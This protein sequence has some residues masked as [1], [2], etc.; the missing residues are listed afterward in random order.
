MQNAHRFSAPFRPLV[1]ALVLMCVMPRLHADPFT[2]TDKQGRSIKADVLSVSGDQVKIKR[3]DGQV[4][5]LPLASLSEDDQKKLKGWAATE[6]AK[7]LP[8][9][10]IQVELSRGKFDTVKKDID[11]TLTNGDLVKNG[12]TLTEEKWGYAITVVNR[13]SQPFDNLRAEYLLFATVDNIHVDE[14]KGLKKKR[15]QTPIATIPELGRTSFRTETISAIKSK[16]NGNIVSAKT[17][18]STSRETLHGVWLRIYRGTEL[19][20]ETAM[21]ENL[22]TTQ[23]W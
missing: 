12:R 20:Y 23:K 2:L 11:V 5:A 19:V 10:A 14:D 1:S 7:P 13:T 8:A 4:F 22:R 17:G 21:P 15:Y 16:Y 9:G 3:D 18:D 6:A